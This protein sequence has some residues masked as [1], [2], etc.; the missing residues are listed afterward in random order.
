[1]A[2]DAQKLCL[3]AFLQLLTSNKLPMK[4]AMAIAGKIYKEFNTPERLG[5]LTDAKLT[6]LGVADK[7][8][9]KLVLSAIGKAG[10][11]EGVIATVKEKERK[12]RKASGGQDTE[13][14]SKPGQSSQAKSTAPAPKRRRKQNV[15]DGRNELLPDKPADEGTTFGS[16]DFEELRD[17][18]AIAERLGFE[19]EEALS[20]SSVY[21]EMNAIAKGVSLGI[22]DEG[23]GKNIEA[24]PHGD[25]PY[26][27]I[28]GRRVPL[29]QTA[30][31]SWRALAVS[32]PAPAGS[33]YSYITRSLRQTTPAVIGA[34]RLLAESYNT[35]EELNRLG[36]AL[37]TDFR[38]EVSEWGKKGEVRCEKILSLRKRQAVKAGDDEPAKNNQATDIITK[39]ERD[40]EDES[41]APLKIGALE[42]EPPDLER[43]KVS[44][45]NEDPDTID[46]WFDDF[47]AD[48]LE[49]LP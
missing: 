22:Y 41:A 3:P 37:Y 23:K 8:D 17:E 48:D 45:M 20:I 13:Q 10:Y 46:E 6:S 32:K 7:E 4:R 42:N 14:A 28:M 2:A 35:A 19:R 12:K 31:G 5:Q 26:V 43:Q 9:R 25:Q 15:N 27:D 36:W 29:Y 18:Q 49:A 24:Q 39:V 16:L 47:T 34:M 30:A 1:M 40:N 38:P 21:T 11:R 33:A 44:T